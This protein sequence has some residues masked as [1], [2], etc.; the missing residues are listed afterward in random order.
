MADAASGA[1]LNR[2]ENIKKILNLIWRG[3]GVGISIVDSLKG[4]AGRSARP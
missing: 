4:R 2:G 3:I 1:S